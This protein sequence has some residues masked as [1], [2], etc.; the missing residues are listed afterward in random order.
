MTADK[1]RK[2]AARELAAAEGI[3][4]TAALRRLSEPP[5]WA[6]LAT[7]RPCVPCPECGT[8][9]LTL[10]AV[11]S[12]PVQ[13]HY[14]CPACGVE[15]LAARCGGQGHPCTFHGRPQHAYLSVMPWQAGRGPAAEPPERPVSAEELAEGWQPLDVLAVLPLG[16]S[17]HGQIVAAAAGLNPDEV[18]DADEAPL[19]V[20]EGMT[21]LW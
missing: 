3:S 2:R 10:F 20:A 18:T 8:G 14:A 15:V 6:P 16:P 1:H 13:W 17:P 19:S 4:Y 11:T 9:E 21:D 7:A 12:P 5:A